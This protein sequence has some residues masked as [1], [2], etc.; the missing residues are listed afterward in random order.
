MTR[1]IG[2][3][4]A[5]GLLSALLFVSVVK[6]MAFGIVLSYVA[7]LPLLMAGL[8]F[9]QAAAWIAVLVGAL[10]VAGA[11]G[12][13]AALPFLIATGIPALVVANRALLWRTAPDGSTE[14]YPPGPI[15]G[16][17]SAAGLALLL[18]GA[19]LVPDHPDG[20]RGWVSETIGQT[21]AAL[22]PEISTEDRQTTVG[23]WTPIFPAMVVGSWLVMAALN[24]AGA[25]GLVVRLGRNRR[26]SPSYRELWLPEWIGWVFVVAVG[27]GIVAGGS[28]GYV[29]GNAAGIL[30]LP[31]SILG[32]ATVHKWAAGRPNARL[33]LAMMYGL[34]ILA[35]VW[36]VIAAAGLGL[37]KFWSM[38][39]RRGESGG[40]EEG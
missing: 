12:G 26:P 16:W 27:L 9:G 35:F 5:A 39:F 11:A 30:L 20:V 8:A 21:L 19:M 32:V 4:L 36:A 15:L 34:L 2:F 13:I 38:R 18:I 3:P 25:Q 23:Y 17:L 10:A 28:V 24:T 1:L 29:A 33:I 40:G 37:V 31:F 22:A 7:P 14:W 6:G